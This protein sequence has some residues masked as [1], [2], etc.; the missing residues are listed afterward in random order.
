MMARHGSDLSPS[1]DWPHLYFLCLMRP[2]LALSLNLWYF[3]LHLSSADYRNLAPCP[4]H[5]GL[6][7][8][9]HRTTAWCVPRRYST[10]SATV[11]PFF[12][13]CVC[14]CVFTYACLSSHYIAQLSLDLEGLRPLP[15]EQKYISYAISSFLPWLYLGL[16]L[17]S[18]APCVS[19]LLMISIPSYLPTRC[20]LYSS[21]FILRTSSI[22]RTHILGENQF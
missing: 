6:R 7:L 20:S 18:C 13:S 2:R 4:G 9:T 21:P 22:S 15:L 16:N 3:C 11:L 14:V 19:D 12:H 8:S 17:G 10:H 1:L 5:V